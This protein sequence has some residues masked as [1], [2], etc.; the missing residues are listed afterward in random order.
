MQQ[1]HEKIADL[2]PGAWF[3]GIYALQNPQIGAT[4]AGKPYLKA[5]LRDAT[6]EASLRCWDVGEDPRKAEQAL[7]RLSET[8]F[9]QISG[10]TENFNDALQIKCQIDQM[11]PVHVGPEELKNLLPSTTHSIDG[12]FQDVVDLL[13]TI[14]HPGVKALADAYLSDAAL[15]SNFRTAPAAT[16]LHHAW[17]GGL[18]EH[19]S[20][21]LKLADQMLPLYPQ[22]SRDVVLLGLFIHDLDKTTELTW[23]KGF[24]YTAEGNLIGH[25]AAGATRLELMAARVRLAQPEN[26]EFLPK[27]TVLALQHILLSHHNLPEHGAAKRPST[28]EAIFVAMLDNLDAQTT[29]S[30]TLADRDREG[31]A[32]TDRVWSLETRLWRVHPTS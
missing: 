23:E 1:G 17:I 21:L 5:I 19:T 9:V 16:A 14:E 3:S 18:L 25:L 24:E 31:S 11:E 8:G 15:M 29:L 6:G 22:L 26:V 32:F 12:M 20:T 10:A 7:S 2:K 13:G 27:H 4:R 30:L 28:P